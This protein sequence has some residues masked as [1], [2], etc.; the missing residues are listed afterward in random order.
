MDESA[1]GTVDSGTSEKATTEGFEV[2]EGQD[3]WQNQLIPDDAPLHPDRDGAFKPS[4]EEG[5]RPA[6]KKKS[7]KAKESAEGKVLTYKE[8]ISPEEGEEPKSGGSLS[9]IEALFTEAISKEKVA[10]A[11]EEEGNG[12]EE[13]LPEG[14]EPESRAARRIKKLVGD[15]KSSHQTHEELRANAWQQYN[16]R[17]EATQ[18]MEHALA[19]RDAQLAALNA[20]VELLSKRPESTEHL[21]D[22]QRIERSWQEKINTAIDE[23]TKAALAPYGEKLDMVGNFLVQQRRAAEINHYKQQ[24]AREA[25]QAVDSVIF[26]GCDAKAVEDERSNIKSWVYAIANDFAARGSNISIADAARV[27]RQTAMKLGLAYVKGAAARN[28]GPQQRAAKTSPPLPKSRHAA[29]PQGD[30]SPN[31][32][33]ANGWEDVVQWELHGKPPLDSRKLPKE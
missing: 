32:L 12:E 8:S 6:T 16:A 7:A 23:R 19:E 31:L 25:D 1:E 29:G 27:L 11:E 14:I 13:E 24:F 17:L 28:K 4:P 5:Q 33:I 30:P 9:D 15:L 18:K 3:P 22:E 10:G 21:T 20:K 26:Q 2:S